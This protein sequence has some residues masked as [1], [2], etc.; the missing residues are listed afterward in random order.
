MKR[1]CLVS[2]NLV[3]VHGT[4]SACGDQVDV[5]SMS[6]SSTVMDLSGGIFYDSFEEVMLWVLTSSVKGVIVEIDGF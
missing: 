3:C 6:S 1:L 4:A 5:D 2:P